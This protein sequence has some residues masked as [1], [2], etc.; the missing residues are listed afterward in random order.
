M[1]CFTSRLLSHGLKV[2]GL[3]DS[4]HEQGSLQACLEFADGEAAPK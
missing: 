3:F 2:E 4:P 1:L